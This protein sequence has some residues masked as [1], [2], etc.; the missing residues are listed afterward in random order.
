MVTLS[1]KGHHPNQ[2]RRQRSKGA[3]SFRG[4]NILEPGHPD[5]LFSSKKLTTFLPFLVDASK[6]KCRR[7]RWDYLIVKIKQIKRAVRYGTIFI[8]CSHYSLLLKQSKAKQSKAIGR[9]EPGWQP[10][11]LTWRGLV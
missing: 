1:E 5:V 7:R 3:R 4:Q 10:G 8:S 2:R 9:A 6:H 11:H